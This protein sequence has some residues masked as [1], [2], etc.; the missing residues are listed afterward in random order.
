MNFILENIKN[1]K[2]LDSGL[3][4]KLEVFGDFVVR[5]PDPEILWTKNRPEIWD[6]FA[7]YNS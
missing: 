3:G 4:E 7:R 2:L 6:Y 5:R 1:Y